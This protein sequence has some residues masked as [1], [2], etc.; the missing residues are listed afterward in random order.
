M[1]SGALA[2]A[3]GTASPQVVQLQP[4][5][6]P[7]VSSLIGFGNC[8][9]LYPLDEPNETLVS[10]PDYQSAKPVY[11]AARYG[12]AADPIFTLV[13]D[14][15][16]GAGTGFNV[17]YADVNNDNRI[18]PERE[19]F[20]FQLG[21]GWGAEPVK[22]TLSVTAGGKTFPY[23][24]EFTAF[25]YKDSD[26]PV[27]K[28][29]A[30]CRNS[31]IMTGEAVFGGKS[32]KVALADLDS[33][34]LFNDYEQGPFRG[35]RFFVD[36]DGNGKFSDDPKS[37]ESF[38][39]AQYA[40]IGEAW[41]TVEASP[42]GGSVQIRTA[43][44]AFGTVRV[45]GCVKAALLSSPRQFQQVEFADGRA[46]TITGTYELRGVKLEI[47]DSAGER[48]STGCNYRSAGPTIVVEPNQEASL[49]DVL[50]LTI[51]VAVTPGPE[52][53]VIELLPQITDRHGGS[54]NTIRKGNERH[55][56]AAH[57]VIK[58]AEGKQIAEAAL[59][60]G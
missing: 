57:L 52:P 23:A 12:D 44:P 28:I 16:R 22:I 47:V 41:Y 24:F 4:F 3:E 40:R 7:N 31:S 18:D 37:P 13:I 21:T 2:Q 54:F 49:P 53:G 32:C 34:G 11:Y 50:P 6:G 60:Y 55:E 46:R 39:Y 38:P 42:D 48:W 15:S 26:N 29:H 17:V 25:P 9:W 35:D 45:A 5:H 56:P 33:N 59:E 8:Q 10:Q 1:A 30:N 51:Q 58:D 19:R 36:L 20:G 43:E 14:E 27:E